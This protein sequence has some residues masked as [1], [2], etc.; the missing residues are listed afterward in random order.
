MDRQDIVNA[1]KTLGEPEDGRP[2]AD[3]SRY[4][5]TRSDAARLVAL[6]KDQEGEFF[7]S[8]DEDDAY[9]VPLHAWRALKPLMPAGLEA[10][11]AGFNVLGEDDWAL[12]EI[13]EVVAAAG[14]AAIA[15]LTDFILNHGNERMAHSLAMD[16][17]S[18]IGRT[19][20]SLRAKVIK[21]LAD[22]LQ[23]LPARHSDLN[24]LLVAHLVEFK[25]VDTQGIM[26]AA[27]AAERV[28]MSICGDLE[29]V[30]IALG[31]RTERSTPRPD[32]QAANRE[33]LTGEVAD[34]DRDDEYDM[35]QIEQVRRTTP[36][37]GRNEPCPCGSG[38]K[39]KKCCG[40][41]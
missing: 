3:Y 22:C 27:F 12:D 40:T 1:L 37:V 10:L 13:P 14:N 25:A 24:G 8:D 20:P 21:T 31:L 11:I 4:G 38:K 41:A 32:Y 26:R 6:I 35:P 15:P 39:Y 33:L 30:E 29:D 23:D 2:W 17:L 19:Q 16:T 28:D 36:K 34:D 9:W 7:T 18:E 5:I